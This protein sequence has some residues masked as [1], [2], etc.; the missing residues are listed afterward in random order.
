MGRGGRRQPPNWAGSPG[1]FASTVPSRVAIRD[2]L[3]NICR[4]FAG[5]GPKKNTFRWPPLGRRCERGA[6]TSLLWRLIGF[7]VNA[8]SR[9]PAGMEGGRND[10]PARKTKLIS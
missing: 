3:N 2:L 9:A 1:K 4:I 8:G 5:G 10:I 6:K 7:L